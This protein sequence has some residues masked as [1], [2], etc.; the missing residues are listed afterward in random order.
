MLFRSVNSVLDRPARNTLV[1]EMVPRD[2]VMK[3][4]GLHSMVFSLNRMAGP[5]LAGYLIGLFGVNSNFFIQG[6]LYAV[7]FA[8]GLVIVVPPRKPSTRPA[9][10]SAELL[11]G[12]RFLFGN[13]TIRLLMVFGLVPYFLIVPV[14]STLLPIYAKDVFH[15][16]P[17]GFGMLLAGVGVGA[18][19]GGALTVALARRDRQGTLQI[20]SMLV[21]C[22]SIL[23][24]AVSPSLAYAI[25]AAVIGGAAEVTF[26]TSQMTMLQMSAP[27]EMRGRVSSLIQLF[28]GFISLGATFS[29]ALAEALGAREIGRAHV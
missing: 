27:G 28:P 21:Y 7:A 16:G 9:S 25:P 26:T 19:L 8:M 23:A 2:I 18:T 14:W 24:L 20:V 22:A 12:F 17:E 4:V 29:G 5:A 11:G 1:F 6:A 15:A 10:V 13:P 3:A